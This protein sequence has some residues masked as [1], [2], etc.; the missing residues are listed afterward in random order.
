M[1]HIAKPTEP[2]RSIHDYV[3][4]QTPVG[5][6]LDY[7]TFASTAS[8]L[9]GSRG[10]QLCDELTQQ[11]FGLCAY[12]GAGIDERLGPLADPN[13]KLKFARHNEHLKPQSDCRKQLIATGKQPGLDLGEDMDHRNIVAALLV[14]G[15]GGRVAKDQLFG[16]AH[17]ENHPV[18][19]LPTDLSCEARFS[20]DLQGFVSTTNINDSSAA[21]TIKVL[22]LESGIL[23]GWR[24][25]AI[26][27]WFEAIE[28]A[29]D[30]RLIL[31]RMTNPTAGQLPEYCFAI[32]QVVCAA[33]PSTP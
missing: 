22:N 31:E 24:E 28:T 32:S 21:A 18:P 17:R 10:G 26:R 2:P 1:R 19:L 15:G 4:N 33:L 6:G 30:A 16:A 9:G 13:A 25:Q 27:V 20:F 5:H 11:Q 8:P 23:R 14:S 29:D 7:K 12:T 3:T